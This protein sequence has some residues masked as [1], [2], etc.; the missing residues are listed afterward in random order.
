MESVDV[1]LEPTSVD[2]APATMHAVIVS[3]LGMNF[4]SVINQARN[5]KESFVALPAG[6]GLLSAMCRDHVLLLAVRGG[7]YLAA[8]VTLQGLQHVLQAMD[9]CLVLNP[10]QSCREPLCAVI[11]CK[12]F[13][14]S[15]ITKFVLGNAFVRCTKDPTNVTLEL[16]QL[17]MFPHVHFHRR[18]SL[19]ANFAQLLFVSS[20]MHSQI[21]SSLET[22]TTRITKIRSLINSSIFN[23]DS[24]FFIHMGPV[25]DAVFKDFI[26]FTTPGWGLFVSFLMV[27]PVSSRHFLAACKAEL[28]DV[29]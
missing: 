21:S 22:S 24:M 11:A 19:V 13:L 8:G 7:H 4:H 23:E 26:A 2:Q 14:S 16:E 17:C 10:L 6:E 28:Y 1:V 18:H 20:N 3:N 29:R 25:D 12:S 9:K 15:V 5:R 27:V